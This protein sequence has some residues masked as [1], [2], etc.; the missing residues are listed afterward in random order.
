MINLALRTEF[1]FQRTYGHIE[2]VVA[3]QGSVVGVA[4]IG[5]TFS[6]FYLNEE[7]K[8][9]GKKPI[10]GVRLMVVKSPES[11]VKPRG[12]YGP[13]Y[14]FIAKNHDGL[15]EIHRLVSRSIECMYYRRHIGLVDVWKLSDNVIV[16]AQHFEVEERIDYI[17]IGY[18]T[19][20]VALNSDLPRVAIVNNQMINAEDKDVYQVFAGS[21]KV[22]NF[23]YPSHILSEKE[24]MMEFNDQE[25][26]DNTYKIAE[27]CNIELET[28]EPVRYNGSK[29]IRTICKKGAKRLGIDL[30]NPE[31]KERFDREISLIREKKFVDYFMVVWEMIDKAK[32]EMLVG[33]GRGSSGGSLVCYLMG[34]TNLDPIKWG[35]LFDRFIDVNRF[36]MPD[37]DIDF[38][39]TKR[40]SVIDELVRTNGNERVK[41][42]AT[43][44]EMK[45]RGAIGDFAKEL[46]IEPEEVDGIKNS[47]ISVS[48]GDARFGESMMHTFEETEI[49]KRFIEKFE[50]M[51]IVSKIENH[52]RHSGKHAAG[53]LV[54]TKNLEEFG[55]ISPSDNTVQLEGKSAEKMGLL[56][57]DCLGLSTLSVLEEIS[58]MIGMDFNDFYSMEFDD[59]ETF[60]LF[61]EVRVKGVFQFEGNALA[62]LC[63]TIKVTNIEDIIAITSLARPG[64]LH[65]GGAAKFSKVHR[66]EEEIE[67]IMDDPDI[68]E[69][70]KDTMGVIIYQE[71]VMKIMR[72]VGG[73][74]WDRVATMRKI[75]SKKG[76]KEAINEFKERFIKGASLK[77]ISKEDS[78]S[79]WKKILEF[80]QYGFN[81]SH[82]VAYGMISYWTAWCKAHHPM[83]FLIANLNSGG[84]ILSKKR[85]IREMKKHH[86]FEIIPV[87]IQLSGAKW[88]YGM[89]AIV[90]G[91]TNINGIGERNAEV[92]IRKR[93]SGE[94]HA[95]GIAKKLENPETKFDIIY[96]C[97]YYWGGL[98]KTP[99]RYGLYCKPTTIENINSEGEYL[100]V[101]Q[102]MKKNVR[103][104]NELQNVLK[105]GGEIYED[106]TK[107]LNITVEDDTGS[108]MCRIGRN[109]YE[110]LG[111]ELAED[112]EEGTDWYLIRGSIISDD[113][114]FIFISD[115]FKL[116]DGYSDNQTIKDIFY[117]R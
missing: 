24:W 54:A 102:L 95:P 43:V 36:D 99:K 42:I 22:E 39:D 35:L 49:G 110:E 21:R 64:P 1:S 53:V 32:K 28:A 67:F 17:G 116:G 46:C 34:I 91:L 6:H 19:S 103:D 50:N 18:G 85:L 16:I 30:K 69:I 5:N 2:N 97:Q 29:K 101:A 94:S 76:G 37:I 89:G 33:P 11:K 78:E 108:I 45:P 8:A 113:I 23:T 12:Q 52:S 75:I 115:I 27:M 92:I 58:E 14:I 105:R 74:P 25:A 106:K 60:K 90:G 73:F 7:C 87:D 55:S 66:G 107:L 41:A 104:L 13:E 93:E 79:A 77:G 88:E 114:I 9:Q 26:V 44:S 59:D 48:S 71:Q 47:I 57:I 117:S 15:V 62:G 86:E 100:L 51:S 84:D 109:E 80:A 40:Q 98:F 72:Q 4:D 31:Y 112:G 70:T 63:R 3:T 83:A 38:P 56:K 81:R 96:P 111:E 61:R 68:R 20:P 65:G 10:F 82:A